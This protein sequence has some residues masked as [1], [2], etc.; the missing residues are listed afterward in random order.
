MSVAQTGDRAVREGK[1]Y[2]GNQREQ[3]GQNVSEREQ[4]TDD[5]GCCALV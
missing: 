3:Q 1:R 4:P 5:M 2:V